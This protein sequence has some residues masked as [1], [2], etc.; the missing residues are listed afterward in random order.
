MA[1]SA[2]SAAP[3]KEKNTMILGWFAF[4]FNAV[5]PILLQVLLGYWLKQKKILS[6]Q[7]AKTGSQFAFRYC[8]SVMQFLNIY[9][10]KS[11]AEI[12]WAIAGFVVVVLFLLCG[13]GLV[14]AHLTTRQ[15]NQKGVIAQ[16]WMRSNSAIIG[17][18]LSEAIGGSAAAAI[19]APLQFP[20][21]IMYNAASV[22]FLT[23]YSDSE[24][25]KISPR[26]LLVKILTNPLI[27]GI[28]CG[29]A[30]LVVRPF[31]PLGADGRPVVSLQYSLP[32]LYSAMTSISRMATPLALVCLGAQFSFSAVKGMGRVITITVLGR[33]VAAP[34]IGFSLAYL[35]SRA[36]LFE[37]S[38]ALVAALVAVFAS[39]VSVSS[40]PMALDMKADGV[41]AGQLVVWTSLFSMFSLFTIIVLFQAIGWL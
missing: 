24:E 20:A 41:L 5:M 1:F 33:L 19:L 12:P 18:P 17:Q 9:N 4:A 15:H 6:E 26:R 8:I 40:A 29:M 16:T 7:F 21:V 2:G 31:I 28:L 11:L 37:L 32:F 27:F 10:L 30:C 13:V 14:M 23:I 35:A 36:G 25:K 38:P 3:G 22:T 39:P 34:A